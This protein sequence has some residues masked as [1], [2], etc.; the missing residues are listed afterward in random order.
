[1]PSKSIFLFIIATIK[2]MKYFFGNYKRYLDFKP[3]FY[4]PVLLALFFNC[5]IW[6][7]LLWRIPSNTTWIPLH[8]YVF[9]GIDWLGPWIYIFIYPA[10]GLIYFLVNLVIATFIEHREPLLCKILLWSGFILQ[11]LIILHLSALVIY[12]FS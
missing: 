4:L 6:F 9:F 8:Y 12:F 2:Q 11:L 10:L 3:S 7:F 1:V 5:F